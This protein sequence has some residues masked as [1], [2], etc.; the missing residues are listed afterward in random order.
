M[1]PA[2]ARTSILAAMAVLAPETALPARPLVTEDAPTVEEE[3]FELALGGDWAAT[4]EMHF[5]ACGTLKAGLLPR[6]DA[7]LSLPC[8]LGPDREGLGQA[9]GTVKFR[10]LSLPPAAVALATYW[11]FD[12]EWHREMAVLT[13]AFTRVIL[14]FNGGVGTSLPARAS[15]VGV[16]GAAVDVPVAGPFCVAVEAYGA[17]GPGGGAT[18]AGGIKVAALESLTLDLGGG[19]RIRGEAPRYRA[20]A[21]FTLL[22]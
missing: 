2:L 7:G 20:T 19:G 6:L 11:N 8:G 21:G 15:T 4:G 16:W 18:G 1:S 22:F 12:G 9:Q 17:A 13:L 10:L 5:D 14:H 3:K